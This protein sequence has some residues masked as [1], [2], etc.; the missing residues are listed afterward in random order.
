[1]QPVSPVGQPE[2]EPDQNE[3]ER[4]LAVLTDVEMRPE[5]WRSQRRERHGGRQKPGEYSEEG[6]NPDEISRFIDRIPLTI[7]CDA[8]IVEDRRNSERLAHAEAEHEALP[9]LHGIPAG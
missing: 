4:V 3:C 5:T 2:C 1:E 9:D 7:T 8:R 6:R